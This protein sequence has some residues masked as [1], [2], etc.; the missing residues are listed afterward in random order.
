MTQLAPIQLE[1]GTVIY[2]EA[3][4]EVAAPLVNSQIATE[5]EEEALDGKGWNPDAAKQQMAQNFQAMQG[6]IRAYTTQTLKAFK[7]IKDTEIGHI[8]KVTLEFGLKIGGEAGIPYIT[9]GT[10]E[11]NLKITVECSFGD[12][13]K[14]ESEKKPD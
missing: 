3:T 11:S 12:E 4:E 9:K 5:E 10:G 7:D 8:S 14:E 2:I 1:D 6:T 13:S